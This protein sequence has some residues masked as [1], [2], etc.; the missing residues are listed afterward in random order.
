MYYSFNIESNKYRQEPS[1]K[2][3]KLEHP[4]CF[5]YV[6][7]NPKGYGIFETTS[8]VAIVLYAKTLI[9]AKILANEKIKN[10]EKRNSFESLVKLFTDKNGFAPN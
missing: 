7:F 1:A 8:G 10:Y 6:K 5:F 3:C 9:E 2:L 4:G